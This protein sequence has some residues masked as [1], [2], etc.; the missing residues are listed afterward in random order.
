MKDFIIQRLWLVYFFLLCALLFV[1]LLV[2]AIFSP[3][4]AFDLFEQAHFDWGKN[5]VKSFWLKN[6]YFTPN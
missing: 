3:S 1:A 5:K 4:K 2:F 6:Y